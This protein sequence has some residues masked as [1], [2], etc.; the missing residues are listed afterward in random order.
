[1][2]ETM[3]EIEDKKKENRSDHE[4]MGSAVTWCRRVPEF[5][6]WGKSETAAVSRQSEMGQNCT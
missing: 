4:D 5:P 1:M 6:R 2:H 3:L